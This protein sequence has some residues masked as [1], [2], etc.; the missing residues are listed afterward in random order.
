MCSLLV[1]SETEI[2][3]KQFYLK[4]KQTFNAKV[5]LAQQKYNQKYWEHKYFFSI[6]L[7]NKC[8]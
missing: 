7:I 3:K 4:H 1:A 5:K 6:Y 2:T 8:S